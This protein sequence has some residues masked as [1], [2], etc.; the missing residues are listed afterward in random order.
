MTLVSAIGLLL[1]QTVIFAVWVA[2][3]RRQRKYVALSA[4]A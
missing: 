2:N 3:K 1:P 4:I